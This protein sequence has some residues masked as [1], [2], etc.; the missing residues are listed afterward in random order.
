M[1]PMSRIESALKSA[2]VVAEHNDCPPRLRNALSYAVFPGG[3]RIRPKLTAS[4]AAA[5][6]ATD[7]GLVFSAAAALELMHC[8]SLV[9]DDM[10]CFDDAQLR[11]GKPSVHLAFGQRLAVLCG[12]GLIVMAFETLARGAVNSPASLPTLIGILGRCASVPTGIV[13]GQAWECESGVQLE[14][15]QQQKTGA[16]FVAATQLGACA[17]GE[18]PAPWAR[19]GERI[20][21]AYQIADDILDVAGK[22]EETGKSNGRDAARLNPNSVLEMGMSA[23]EDR[24]RRLVGAAVDSIP[25]CAGKDALHKLIATEARALMDTALMCHAAA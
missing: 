18:D 8:A 20:G 7:G 19:L 5:C 21:E 23:S 12:D 10:P 15:Y 1:D 6:G 16:L 9:H 4:V 11:R 14:R 2:L 24:L 3:A 17:A 25:P 22:P 13:A